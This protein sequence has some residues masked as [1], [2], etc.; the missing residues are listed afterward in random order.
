MEYEY[1]AD[2]DACYIEEDQDEIGFANCR[3][4]RVNLDERT[5]TVKHVAT[6]RGPVTGRAFKVP[7]YRMRPVEEAEGA[8]K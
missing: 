7:F 8:G 6:G 1:E 3:V 4:L 2:E 5:A